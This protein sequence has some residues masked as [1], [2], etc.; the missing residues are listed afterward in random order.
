MVA[1]L[2]KS[3]LASP[4]GD[5]NSEVPLFFNTHFVS[6]LVTIEAIWLQCRVCLLQLIHNLKIMDRILEAFEGNE[7][8]Q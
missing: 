2:L 8:Q 6:L 7:E 4:V 5:R 3:L 1:S